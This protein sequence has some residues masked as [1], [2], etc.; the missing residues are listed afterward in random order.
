MKKR[1]SKESV[2]SKNRS[3]DAQ[4][5]EFEKRDLGDDIRAS[6]AARLLERATRPTSIVLEED[7]IEELRRKGAKRGLGYQT[8]LKLV[9]REHLGEY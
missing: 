7:L 2:K 6:R 8:M 9:V 4:L 3:T 5:R 1:S